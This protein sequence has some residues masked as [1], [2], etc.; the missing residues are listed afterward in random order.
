[1]KQAISSASAKDE[2]D[3]ANVR[4]ELDS[5]KLQIKRLELINSP[6][7]HAIAMICEAAVISWVNEALT[8][9]TGYQ[10]IQAI[11]R[12]LADALFGPQIDASS[13]DLIIRNLAAKQASNLEL[14]HCRRDSLLGTPADR[15]L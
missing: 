1:M 12:K 6:T 5:L 9:I 4:R 2:A 8:R 11:G 15:T 3:T 13:I 7:Q 10:T 14:V